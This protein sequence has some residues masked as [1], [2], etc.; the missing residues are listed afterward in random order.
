VSLVLL[1][2]YDRI[3]RTVLTVTLK[4][5]GHEVLFASTVGEIVSAVSGK[6]VSTF[7][8][9]LDAPDS[10]G[11]KMI[12]YLRTLAHAKKLRIIAVTWRQDA[13]FLKQVQQAGVT[14]ILAKREYTPESLANL[15]DATPRQVELAAK[16]DVPSALAPLPA[17]GAMAAATRQLAPVAPPKPVAVTIPTKPLEATIPLTRP[18]IDAAVALMT[19]AKALKPILHQVIAMAGNPTVSVDDLIKVLR[20]DIELS[21]KV[22][23]TASSPTFRRRSGAVKNL[24][25]AVTL[26]GMEATRQ[27]AMSLSAADLFA[28]QQTDTS[29]KMPGL[30]GHAITCAH[31]CENLARET[32]V[33][34][35]D[36]AFIVGLLHDLGRRMMADHLQGHYRQIVNAGPDTLPLCEVERKV[37][38]IDHAVLGSMVA[39]RWGCPSFITRAIKLHHARSLDQDDEN[40]LGGLQRILQ[41]ANAVA[42]SLGFPGD[43]L[44]ELPTV[45][46]AW[47]Q[48][49]FPDPFAL[50]DRLWDSVQDNLT[51]I[52]SRAD[53]RIEFPRPWKGDCRQLVILGTRVLVLDPLQLMLSHAYKSAELVVP[54]KADSHLA[55]TLLVADLR[56]AANL[57]EA[58]P[59]LGMLEK[60][61]LPNWPVLTVLSSPNIDV[62]K[63][64]LH[65]RAFEAVTMPL[66]PISVR[67]ATQTL[68]AGQAVQNKISSVTAK[69]A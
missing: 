31:L 29:L 52:M 24:A 5:S 30:W 27:L 19:S 16:K 8:F 59:A 11:L 17:A 2:Q 18:Q 48:R 10:G 22:I 54:S 21:A 51:M 53:L 15:V 42:I 3:L 9:D 63:L 56:S 64:P 35:P 32:K 65:G 13:A 20:N 66:R 25:D 45:P 34:D 36:Q 47:L 58:I 69:A 61:N 6:A 44:E 50:R 49:T 55:Q 60:A 23:A 12:A 57:E 7:V 40:T 37:V 28:T 62:Q 67:E 46:H 1:T 38:G 4:K 39:E 26:I 68:L 41:F 33:C 43:A 14:A